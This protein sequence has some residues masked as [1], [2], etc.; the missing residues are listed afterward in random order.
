VIEEPTNPF[1]GGP[2]ACPFVAFEEDRDH[3]ASGADY[4]HRCFA[5]PEPEPRAF[6]HQERYCLSADFPQCPVF[7]DWARQEAA[8]VIDE[9]A[10]VAAATAG[11]AEAAGA[12][13]GRTEDGAAAA[14]T[15]AAADEV[16]AP[17][18]LA[19]LARTTPTADTLPSSRHAADASAGL[20]SYDGET[21]RSPALAAPLPPSS[22]G[23][24]AVSMARRG[25]SHPG[26]ENPPRLET[27]PRLRSR[28]EH[29]ANQPLLFAAVG[30]ALVMVALVVFPIVISSRNGTP[31]ASGSPAAL[32]GG[33]AGAP[34]S[35]APSDS[36]STGSP[37]T[38]FTTYVVQKSDVSGLSGIAGK[39]NLTLTTLEAANPQ[40]ANFNVIWAGM[41]INIPP[42]GWQPAPSPSS[43]RASPSAT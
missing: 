23:E 10:A 28:E 15:A 5:A 31:A 21:K 27:F 40:I 4:R 36:G 29:R 13:E 39:F 3:R 30:V 16:A 8:G 1:D 25:P 12:G 24:P 2:G 34:Q 22:L 11:G 6:P 14:T 18:F 20:W 35:A 38:G 33:S 41:I 9:G 43:S 42:P 37:A 32:A 26:W 17:A 7:L 19:A